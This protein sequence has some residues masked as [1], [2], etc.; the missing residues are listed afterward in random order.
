[1]TS[2]SLSDIDSRLI[3]T[4]WCGDPPRT[5]L[6]PLCT[7]RPLNVQSEWGSERTVHVGSFK[8]TLSFISSRPQCSH[9]GKIWFAFSFFLFDFL[10]GLSVHLQI[11]PRDSSL[12]ACCW[13]DFPSAVLILTS[14]EAFESLCSLVFMIFLITL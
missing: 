2:L 9:T 14:F 8:K 4:Y 3:Q 1:M 5:T 6:G 7:V 12:W 10:S 11:S 13:S